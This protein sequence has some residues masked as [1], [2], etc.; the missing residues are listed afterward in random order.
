DGEVRTLQ[1]KRIAMD[2]DAT[3]ERD[4]S[5]TGATRSPKPRWESAL[6]WLPFALFLSGLLFDLVLTSLL[7]IDWTLDARH[8]LNDI[9]FLLIRA[10]AALYAVSALFSDRRRGFA[11][12]RQSLQYWSLR[13][14]LLGAV[15][16]A[17]FFVWLAVADLV[18]PPL[19]LSFPTSL[20]P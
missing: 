2:D 12:T 9:G 8:R 7:P 3:R 10:G 20:G 1:L 11:N 4:A 16:L 14:I 5:P 18:S 6:H 13:L 17:P 19:Q 15:A